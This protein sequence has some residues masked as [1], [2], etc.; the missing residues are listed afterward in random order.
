[1]RTSFFHLR[2]RL[3]R[4]RDDEHAH[5]AAREF[6]AFPISLFNRENKLAVLPVPVWAAPSR[7]RPDRIT[8]MACAWMGVGVA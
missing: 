1:M 4:R 6:E 3:A 8:G 5:G 7:S 2:R